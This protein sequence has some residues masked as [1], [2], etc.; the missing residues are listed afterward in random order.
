M[1]THDKNEIKEKKWN[2]NTL[3]LLFPNH[4]DL[5][6]VWPLQILPRWLSLTAAPFLSH[7]KLPTSSCQWLVPLPFPQLKVAQNVPDLR[8]LW[9]LNCFR[10]GPYLLS[11]TSHL[12]N[13]KDRCSGLN[14]RVSADV[15]GKRRH[16]KRNIECYIYRQAASKSFV[17]KSCSPG[18]AVGVEQIE[19]WRRG[20]SGQIPLA[21]EGWL[22]NTK[23]KSWEGRLPEIHSTKYNIEKYIYIN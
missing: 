22:K 13:Y 16:L 5:R 2:R 20:F 12:A 11:L 21:W 19:M 10:S 1:Q 4:P 14:W 23:Y 17:F 7:A 8:A 6:A 15:K 3:F 9:P 18:G